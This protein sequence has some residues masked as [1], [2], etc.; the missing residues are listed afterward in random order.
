V[1]VVVARGGLLEQHS[2]GGPPELLAGLAHRGERDRGGRGEVDVVVADD[3]DVLW[4]PD[5]VPGHL[6]QD[7]EGDQV[8]GAEHRGGPVRRRQGRDVRAGLLPRGHVQCPDVDHVQV[9][10]RAPGPLE[11][12][13]RALEPVGHLPDGVRAADVGDVP[14]A[15]GQQVGDREITAEHVVDR[16]RALATGRRPA[17]D[18]HDRGTPPLQ[19]GE[20]RAR[21]EDRRDQHALHP[22]LFKQLQVALL[23]AFLVV[24]VAQDDRQARLVRLVFHAARHVGEERVGHV[25][26]HQ[27][28]G[29]AAAGPELAGGLV[30]DETELPD[31][32]A[33]PVTRGPGHDVRPVEHV[34]DRGDGDAGVGR[35]FPD[36]D[37]HAYPLLRGQ[38]D[39]ALFIL[40]NLPADP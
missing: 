26:H 17:V 39:R 15:D 19:P 4:H 34:G 32:G 18:E 33:Y 23:L 21:A 5:L 30:P 7:A 40:T 31:R 1:L 6:L 11:G 24:A 22:V 27:A 10:G 16:D 37:R 28:D 13:Q 25:K 12:A 35:D 36:A 8:V 38:A 14:V 9:T 29:P 2:R 3:R 20:P